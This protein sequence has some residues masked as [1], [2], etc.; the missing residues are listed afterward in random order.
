MKKRFL[1]TL[2]ALALVLCVAAQAPE[3]TDNNPETDT[4]TPPPISVYNILDLEDTC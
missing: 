3:V 4:P 1:A 2:A